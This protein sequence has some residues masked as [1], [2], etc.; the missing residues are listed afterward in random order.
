MTPNIE[1][2]LARGRAMTPEELAQYLR[3]HP[4]TPA[5]ESM[6]TIIASVVTAVVKPLKER[7]AA[8]ELRTKATDARL[9]AVEGKQLHPTYA[10]VHDAHREY[11]HGDLV[12][13]G[14][15]LW[16]CIERTTATPG[17]NPE[18]WRLIVKSGGA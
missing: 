13:R 16:L 14:G 8:L 10:G 2:E 1:K 11:R 18:A 4:P 3:D 9:V 7:I 6:A 12:T 17:V 15:G 5:E